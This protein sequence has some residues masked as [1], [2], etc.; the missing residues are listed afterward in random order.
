M[1]DGAVMGRPVGNVL[2][3]VVPFIFR[4]IVFRD[5]AS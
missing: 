3:V 4:V 5:S 2:L 1:W